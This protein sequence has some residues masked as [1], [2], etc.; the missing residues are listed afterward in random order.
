VRRALDVVAAVAVVLTAAAPAARAQSAHGA[1]HLLDVPYLAQ[2]EALCG[3]AA[4]A[5]VMRFWGATGVYAETFAPLVDEAAGGISGQ[6]LLDELRSRGWQAASFGG[7]RD[8]VRSHLEQG[9][10]VIVLIED[11][12]SRFHYVVIV[13][14]LN[15][16]VI[17]HDP[18]R[19]PFRVVDEKTLI[20]AWRRS[21]YWTLVALPA[22]GVLRPRED[23]AS[24]A[25]D[26]AKATIAVLEPGDPSTPPTAAC[27]PMIA[28]GVRLAGAGDV[29]GARGVFEAAADAC[30]ASPAPLRELAGLHAIASRWREA[31]VD[32]RK[33]LERDDADGHSWRILATSLY[34]EGDE[35]G[36]LEAW[37]RIGEPVIELVKVTGLQRTRY[38]VVTAAIG[39]Q[40]QTLLTVRGLRTA[41]RRLDELPSVQATRLTYVP[42]ENGRAEIEAAV[43][44]R[45]LIPT[46][47]AALAASG[48]RL[49][50]DRTVAAVIASPT[51]GGE[52]WRAAWRWETHRPRV[53]LGLSVPA[54]FGGT[55]RL[56]AFTER[57]T[58]QDA[59]TAIEARRG[60]SLHVVNWT[61]RGLRWETLLDVDRWG[62][63][64]RS[65][66]LGLSIEQRLLDDRVSVHARISRLTGSVNTWTLGGGTDWRSR[67]NNQGNVLIARVGF[68]VAG[69]N[70]PLALWPG[71]GTGQ[72]RSELLRGHSLLNGG[73][74][75][76]GV[77]GRRLAHG[78]AEWRHWLQP[79]RRPLT[80][81]PAL[82]VDVARASRGLA[83]FDRRGHVDA[84][85]GVRVVMPGA[86]VLRIDVARGLRDGAM[87]LSAGW[88]K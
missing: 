39:L 46:S 70:A 49:F 37:N 2:S 36:A 31:A 1:V 77:F 26:D 68:D 32:A 58:Y 9:R 61:A 8:Q 18:A 64:G 6:A 28:E 33:A 75:R 12:P 72:G 43:L 5:M 38:S 60:A 54:P 79:K 47:L 51:G 56:S 52:V 40:P 13:G 44:E 16:R 82:F 50:T 74:I 4:I 27:A 55:W 57:Q 7:D 85:A 63:G 65:L 86:G 3:G 62:D 21:D 76:D 15:G 23:A 87:A 41:K 59:E 73:V 30:P 67:L 80:I 11:R 81:A 45:P 17:L 25:R 88:T 78:G 83:S 24:V 19:A 66:S 69:T 48:V 35:A 20:E 84:G 22:A 10:P 53:E 42:G 34:L 29:D 71:A 14:W